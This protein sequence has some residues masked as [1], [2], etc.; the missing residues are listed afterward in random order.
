MSNLNGFDRLA[1][2]YDPLKRVIFGKSIDD[3][4]RC[5]LNM[6]PVEGNI[7]VLGGGSGNILV[8]LLEMRPGCSIWYI[9][10]SSE[11]ILRAAALVSDDFRHKVSFIHG[12][13]EAIP[14]DVG[15]DG[16]ITNFFLDLFP[17][18]SLAA[19]CQTIERRLK[20]GATWLISDFVDGRKWW[21]RVLLRL[22]YRFFVITCDI[23]ARRLP[24]WEDHI[25][26]A[27]MEANGS[28][29][30][31]NGFIKSCVYRKSTL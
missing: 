4:Q 6:L 21:Q 11:M 12:T 1:R 31:Y 23:E 2:F 26:K 17:D 15:F 7:L 16:V 8:A 10:A 18:H 27:G 29:F 20:S 13:E 22:M 3:A 9:D 19:I 28:R 25:R 30:F 5:F 24:N 14:Q